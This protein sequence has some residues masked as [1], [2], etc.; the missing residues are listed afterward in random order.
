MVK[1]TLMAVKGGM[2]G[3]RRRKGKGKGVQGL[4]DGEGR[5][6]NREDRRENGKRAREGPTS[7][8]ISPASGIVCIHSAREVRVFKAA[9]CR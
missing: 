2:S 6:Q 9:W 4:H 3:L 8:P 5:G 1:G 7:C